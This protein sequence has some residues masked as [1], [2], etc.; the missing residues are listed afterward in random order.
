MGIAMLAAAIESREW[1][2]LDY[3]NMGPGAAMKINIDRP[4]LR[5]WLATGLLRREL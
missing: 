5:S 3:A 4:G 2:A 1:R